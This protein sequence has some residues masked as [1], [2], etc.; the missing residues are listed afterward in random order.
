MTKAQKLKMEV[1]LRERNMARA[2][3]W[4]NFPEP[5]PLHRP[6]AIGGTQAGWGYN[7]YTVTVRQLWRTCTAIY[8]NAEL[9]NGSRSFQ[10]LY[11]TE[12][13]AWQALYHSFSRKCA[14]T[15]ADILSKAFP[16]GE[17]T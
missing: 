7:D 12:A 17:P 4:P 14:D 6:E 9:K 10:P 15:L 1:L 16:K 5:T 2:L 8:D 3:S 13:E 11:A